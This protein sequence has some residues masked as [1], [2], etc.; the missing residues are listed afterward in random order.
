MAGGEDG[1]AVVED[2][3]QAD[4]GK[5]PGVAGRQAAAAPRLRRSVQHHARLS[6]SISRST[7]PAA[8]ALD[9][10]C[11]VAERFACSIPVPLLPEDADP[12]LSLPLIDGI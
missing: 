8:D 6:R 12:K 4:L 11:K 5:G 2:R 7:S 1:I 3:W 9:P 10:G